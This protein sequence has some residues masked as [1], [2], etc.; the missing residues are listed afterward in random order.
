ME[1]NN[2]EFGGMINWYLE[3]NICDNITLSFFPFSSDAS[4]NSYGKF[5]FS[6]HKEI[7]GF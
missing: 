5:R 2:S 6:L 3:Q 4:N 1:F 7:N